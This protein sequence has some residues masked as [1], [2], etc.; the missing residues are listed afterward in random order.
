MSL[1]RWR[2][3]PRLKDWLDTAWEAPVAVSGLDSP[4]KMLARRPGCACRRPRSKPGSQR[5]PPKP[6]DC[7]A[8]PYDLSTLHVVANELPGEATRGRAVLRRPLFAAR[9]RLARWIMESGIGGDPGECP[10]PWP[11]C[12]KSTEPYL[13]GL[14]PPRSARGLGGRRPSPP[15]RRVAPTHRH[16]VMV[17]SLD[18]PCNNG[19]IRRAPV[20]RL[21]ERV[22]LERTLHCA[23]LCQPH[24]TASR[25]LVQLE[26]GGTAPGRWRPALQPARR[27]LTRPSPAG[28]TAAGRRRAWPLPAPD[29]RR[30]R[31]WHCG[32]DSTTTPSTSSSPPW[33]P[34]AAPGAGAGAG[35]QSSPPNPSD[36]EP[37]S[38]SPFHRPGPRHQRRRRPLRRAANWSTTRP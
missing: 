9:W 10:A 24:P 18:G 28:S 3:H 19:R 26:L 23:Q 14:F 30:L 2:R 4:P 35:S 33:P 20:R 7:L 37:A 25:P 38:R 29:Q 12:F 32:S 11:P 1:F 5:R 31:P 22:R 17:A 6:A 21:R 34:A 8:Q 13:E 16:R 27:D 15:H 36:K